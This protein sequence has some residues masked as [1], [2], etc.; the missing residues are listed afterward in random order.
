MNTDE[1]IKL[2]KHLDSIGAYSAAD[3]TE[4]NMVKTAAD[5]PQRDVSL[6]GQEPGGGGF[7]AKN[8]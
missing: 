7:F 2:A 6:Q 4:K 1:Y 5:E 8:I 3:V